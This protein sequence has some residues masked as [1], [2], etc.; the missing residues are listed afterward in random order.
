MAAGL[1]NTS[2]SLS[3]LIIQDFLLDSAAGTGLAGQSPGTCLG[4]GMDIAQR[5]PSGSGGSPTPVT[6]WGSLT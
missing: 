5:T 3:P 1:P 6:Q 2:S 4:L